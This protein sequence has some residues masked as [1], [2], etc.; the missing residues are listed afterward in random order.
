MVVSNT[1]A[2]RANAESDRRLDQ[3]LQAI[4]DYYTGVGEEVLLGQKEFHT[5]RQ[6]LLEKPAQF[7]KNMAEELT[8]VSSPSER[9]KGLL[10][11]GRF[12]LGK[13]YYT[14][15]KFDEAGA[16]FNSAA[17]LYRELQSGASRQP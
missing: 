4:E 12:G 8:A 14:L 3:T 2:A 5:L 9:T 6:R 13:I 17:T 16:E 1:R 11:K 15:G 10:A 7:Y